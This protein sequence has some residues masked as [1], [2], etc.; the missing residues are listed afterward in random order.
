[1]AIYIALVAVVGRLIFDPTL[2]GDLFAFSHQ[3]VPQDLDVLHGLQQT[4]SDR[5]AKI[6][7]NLG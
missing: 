7:L 2:V 5:K 1:M 6:S 3:L 4:V